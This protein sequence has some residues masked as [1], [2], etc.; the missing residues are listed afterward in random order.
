MSASKERPSPISGFGS[1][2][3]MPA[4]DTRDLRAV[5]V[6]AIGNSFECLRLQNS[7]RLLGDIGKYRITPFAACGLVTG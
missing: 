3:V 1:V 2:A 7:L 6:V 5:E 4:R